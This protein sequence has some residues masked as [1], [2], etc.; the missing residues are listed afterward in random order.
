MRAQSVR[1]IAQVVPVRRAPQHRA[2]VGQH[3][4][5]TDSVRGQLEP[6]GRF[7]ACVNGLD[8]IDGVAVKGPAGSQGRAP[9]ISFT[10]EDLHPHDVCT[11][12]DRHG[13]ALRG[14]HHCAQPLMEHWDLDGTTRA[15]LAFYND[16][17]DIDALLSGLDDAIALLR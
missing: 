14:G 1:N 6:F 17:G 9:V 11:L 4:Q 13:V 7:G 10:V 12:L 8:A 16:D 15:S 3:D 5:V 2:S